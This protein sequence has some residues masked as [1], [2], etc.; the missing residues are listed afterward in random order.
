MTVNRDNISKLNR[1]RLLV[2]AGTLMALPW[3]SLPRRLAAA[4]PS[5]PPQRLVCVAVHLSLYPGDWFPTLTGSD[6]QLPTLL[7]PIEHLRNQ[8]TLFSGM[9]HPNVARGH[10]GEPAFLSGL[11]KS[12]TLDQRV[13]RELN[14]DTRFRSLQLASSSYQGASATSWNR[15]GQPLMGEGR[16]DR[17]FDQLF[18][19][20]QSVG[21]AE[22]ALTRGNSVL[23][24]VREDAKAIRKMWSAGD[25][26]RLDALLDAVREVEQKVARERQWV[27][28][29]K[30]QVQ[31]FDDSP[32]T[33]HENLER[34]F[35]L[36]ALALQTDSTRI[37]SIRL[38]GGGLPIEIN[39]KSY[40]SDYHGLSHH[41]KDPRT[42]ADLLKV[43][44]AHMNAF[45]R[46][47][48]RLAAIP[49]GEGTLLDHTQVLFGSGLG[50]G[51]SHS[52]HHLPVLLAGGDFSHGQHVALPRRK[53]LCDL[54]VTM[55]QKMGF[56]I[57]HFG[58][59]RNNLNEVFA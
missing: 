23:D 3:V 26:D 48:D 13:A 18:V 8:F 5:Q 4:T 1:R 54:Y 19:D 42:I 51:S 7:Q 14:P 15:N 44:G 10:D 49:D 16:V 45:A 30:P 12:E 43:E 46:F 35:D 40:G 34:V 39:G 17:I 33:Y 59:S 11:N 50:N 21:E 47:L 32:T 27:R 56:E 20:P 41:G 53:P 58:S 2:G 29:P 37:I 6:Y 22:A 28:Q 24:A 31:A 25:K 52:T 9:D 57:D 55:L 36:A 38:N